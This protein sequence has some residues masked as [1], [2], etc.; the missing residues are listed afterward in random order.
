MQIKEYGFYVW[1]LSVFILLVG[2]FN[3]TH[4]TSQQVRE[5]EDNW[6]TAEEM[7]EIQEE[8][9]APENPPSPELLRLVESY[10]DPSDLFDPIVNVIDGSV[11]ESIT[12]SGFEDVYRH[13][14]DWKL[15]PS[16]WSDFLVPD[17][18]D[19]SPAPLGLATKNRDL[20]VVFLRAIQNNTIEVQGSQLIFSGPSDF[21]TELGLAAEEY[22]VEVN[23]NPE[24]GKIDTINRLQSS[25]CYPLLQKTLNQYSSIR[26][27]NIRSN[28]GFSIGIAQSH[29]QEIQNAMD[30]RQTGYEPVRITSCQGLTVQQNAFRCISDRN[31]DDNLSNC[32]I[33]TTQNNMISFPGLHVVP[34]LPNYQIK[35][36]YYFNPFTGKITGAYLRDDM[37]VEAVA[38]LKVDEY[39]ASDEEEWKTF[40][41]TNL[42]PDFYGYKILSFTNLTNHDKP[43]FDPDSPPPPLVAVV[44][45]SFMGENILVPSWEEEDLTPVISLAEYHVD[46]F[47]LWAFL[48]IASLSIWGWRQYRRSLVSS[49]AKDRPVLYWVE[50]GLKGV[51][52][53]GVFSLLWYGLLFVYLEV[54]QEIVGQD[55]DK[56]VLE[57]HD[58]SHA[59]PA[60]LQRGFQVY[61]EVC[62]GCHS[63]KQLHYRDLE[64]IFADGGSGYVVEGAN[65]DD[66]NSIVRQIASQYE[67]SDGP[68]EDGEM[69]ERAAR[70]S[71]RFVS[72][73]DND[74]AARARNGGALPPDLSLIV[75]AREGGADYIH[76]LLT[77]YTEAPLGVELDDGVY[78]NKA[79]YGNKIAMSE[80]L[81]EDLVDYNDGTPASVDQ[82]A[83][84]VTY[85]L[86]WAADPVLYERDMSDYKTNVMILCGVLS[87]V[88]LGVSYR[89]WNLSKRKK[90]RK[91]IWDFLSWVGRF[92][93]RVKAVY[94]MVIVVAL[95]AVY[96][97]VFPHA[98][99]NLAVLCDYGKKIQA[100]NKP[101]DTRALFTDRVTIIYDYESIK[102]DGTTVLE[103]ETTLLSRNQVYKF[104]HSLNAL[105]SVNAEEGY[106]SDVFCSLDHDGVY[107][108]SITK[109]LGADFILQPRENSYDFS[110]V[111]VT[112]SRGR[113]HQLR[114]HDQSENQIVKNNLKVFGDVTYTNSE[115]ISA[116]TKKIA[117]MKTIKDAESL[118]GDT[119]EVIF[120]DGREETQTPEYVWKWFGS[121][122]SKEIKEVYVRDGKIQRI[123]AAPLPYISE[124]CEYAKKLV[125]IKTMDD[126]EKL[127]HNSIRIKSIAHGEV[128]SNETI[129]RT[130]MFE[131]RLLDDGKLVCDESSK[132]TKV[133]DDEGEKEISFSIDDG[134]ISEIKMILSESEVDRGV[135]ESINPEADN[136][137]DVSTSQQNTPLKQDNDPLIEGVLELE[138]KEQ[139]GIDPATLQRG[140]QV[141]SLVCTTCHSTKHL[142]YS[143]L[144]PIFA[145]GGSGYFVY[146]D[147]YEKLD[148]P[149]EIVKQIASESSVRDGLDDEGEMFTRAALPSDRFVLPYDND[150]E[151][152]AQNDG[153]LPP[154]LSLIVSAREGG[155]DYIHALLTGY[156]EA[157][158]GIS[159]GNGVY[160]NKAIPGN[161]IKMPQPLYDDFLYYDDG[162]PASLDQLARDVANFL[163][164]SARTVNK[165][166]H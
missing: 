77:G 101:S 113:I 11:T 119:I 82:M 22:T 92:F 97:F 144:E 127:L 68:N 163:E 39:D 129:S 150:E 132:T 106:V 14:D 54:S 78:Y 34:A 24:T 136:E 152:R 98:Q 90:K 44:I 48:T 60:T 128:V 138:S 26:G 27:L 160:Y 133:I 41:E 63:M 147:D 40:L 66:P 86:K 140:Y 2:S 93:L 52:F 155:A 139:Q 45:A 37:R 145:D 17:D 8:N 131:S 67:V 85:F 55:S 134:R 112:T 75:S 110:L 153:A 21:Y 87:V 141:Y 49:E 121:L 57:K 122:D 7:Q 103:Q 9:A 47:L 70:P 19:F 33:K 46:L 38:K 146:D 158:L 149:K 102:D 31:I 99:T 142:H 62:A 124:T 58:W 69:Y 117:G 120:D 100:L 56:F 161:K 10:N 72:P 107:F 74:E 123:Y 96:W 105:A 109:D 130:E 29:F 159:L 32:F 165:K 35:Y 166:K 143:D 30:G 4:R 36:D 6:I 84:D 157:P 104:F 43:L 13:T 126:A 151:A 108:R 156:T 53:L 137:K 18:S 111:E 50:A 91:W 118:L 162:T 59:E 148:D 12:V 64:P 89:T 23:I 51:L 73:Y 125:A 79:M 61:T 154:D 71:D 135:D 164:W 115:E 65:P 94:W 5:A 1:F 81:S 80:P 83:R 28:R 116:Y 20:L 42:V 88:L 95:V 16:W 25:P 114:L 76:A 15:F 3:S